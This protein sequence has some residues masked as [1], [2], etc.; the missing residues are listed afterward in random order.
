M[1]HLDVYVP[2]WGRDESRSMA[3]LQ[4]S[5]SLGGCPTLAAGSGGS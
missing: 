4:R 5:L 1:V 3:R 2:F